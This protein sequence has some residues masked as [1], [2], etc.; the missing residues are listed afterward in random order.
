M[1]GLERGVHS[2]NLAHFAD[3]PADLAAVSLS[4]DAGVLVIT[5]SD[6]GIAPYSLLGHNTANLHLL[7]NAGNMVQ[8][9]DAKN[10]TSSDQVECVLSQAHVDHIAVCGHLPCNVANALLEEAAYS[11]VSNVARWLEYAARTRS[12]VA[13]HYSTLQRRF[14]QEVFVQENVLLQLE[15]LTTVPIVASRLTKG[16]L[17]L[18]GLVYSANELFA[19]VPSKE[20]FMH[21]RDG[22]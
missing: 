20:Q 16:T 18:H 10:P 15:H 4:A 19:Y 17:R 2:F 22:G 3:S 9:F 12:I 21:L 11:E 14:L 8:P 5:C 7:Q 6:L 13:Q 1:H